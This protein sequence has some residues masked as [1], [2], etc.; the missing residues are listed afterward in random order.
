MFNLLISEKII[1]KIILG[2]KGTSGKDGSPGY[3][4]EFG[5]PGL[6]GPPGPPGPSGSSGV[7]QLPIIRNGDLDDI[8]VRGICAA[9]IR[10][11]FNLI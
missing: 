7:E 9:V 10:G 6:P 1:I 5:Q 2:E 4:G 3:P 8:D 11:D